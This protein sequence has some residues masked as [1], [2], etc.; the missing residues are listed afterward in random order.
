[1]KDLNWATSNTAFGVSCAIDVA[2]V[3]V[4]AIWLA[5]KPSGARAVLLTAW[6]VAAFAFKG[7]LLLGLGLTVPFGVAHVLWLDL[8]VAL[9]AGACAYLAAGR[10][11]AP[12]WSLALAAAA[13]LSV[14]VGV[15]AAFVEPNQVVTEHATVDLAAARKGAAPVRVGV[16]SD[17][18]FEHVGDHEAEAVSDLMEARPDV[19]LLAGDFHQGSRATLSAELPAIHALLGSLHAPGGVYAVQGD[20]EG[21]AEARRVTAGTGI[22]LLANEVART[23]VG[24]RALTIAGVRLEWWAPAARRTAR[25]LETRTGS[26]DIR[27]LLSHR[28]DAA[29]HLARNTRVDL[30]V[31]G[32]THGGQFQLPLIGPLVTASDVPR[33]VGA[34]GLH[35]LGG[36]RIYVSRGVGV[37]RS[38]APKL[39][40]RA[41]PEVA[42]VTLR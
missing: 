7:V 24:D 16:M 42:V 6:A 39:R 1:M 11:S 26:G 34:G 18:Q 2:I 14:P 22:R 32:H 10:R 33:D 5:G 4:A 37:E 31:A 40:F 25:R 23:K 20:A 36:R 38:Q 17:L 15:Y 12:G 21:L 30:T 19:I 13:L 35:D 27:I 3:C 8:V 28:P 41:K 9:P 29:L